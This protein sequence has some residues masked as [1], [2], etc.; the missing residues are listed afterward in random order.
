MSS[1]HEGCDYISQEAINQQLSPEKFFSIG[2]LNGALAQH[3]LFNSPAPQTS[4]KFSITSST[5][6]RGKRIRN[7]CMQVETKIN[8]ITVSSKLKKPINL[9]LCIQIKFRLHHCICYVKIFKTNKTTLDYI[10]KILFFNF[11]W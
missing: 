11:F 5:P 6:K 7:A 8:D 2:R 3:T 4:W 10:R 9:K 1:N